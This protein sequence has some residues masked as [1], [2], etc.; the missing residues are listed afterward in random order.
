[1]LPSSDYQGLVGL[2][3]WKE[4]DHFLIKCQAKLFFNWNTLVSANFVL[5]LRGKFAA[6]CSYVYE[7]K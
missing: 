7:P 3:E 6:I 1:M 2:Q 5:R 4:I